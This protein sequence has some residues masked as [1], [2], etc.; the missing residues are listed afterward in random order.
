MA[1]KCASMNKCDTDI[2][3]LKGA[4]SKYNYHFGFIQTFN[5]KNQDLKMF[6]I[7]NA[8]QLPILQIVHLIFI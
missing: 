2:C 1:F 3:I 8:E 4:L 6:K 7:L 5:C